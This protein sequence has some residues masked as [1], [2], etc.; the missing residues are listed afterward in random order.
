MDFP[1]ISY[2]SLEFFLRLFYIIL[3]FTFISIAGIL[4]CIFLIYGYSAYRI[5]LFLFSKI[6]HTYGL[7]RLI[8]IPYFSL[9]YSIQRRFIETLPI[10]DARNLQKTNKFLFNFT[11]ILRGIFIEEIVFDFDCENSNTVVMEKNNQTG[12]LIQM[13]KIQKYQSK[14]QKITYLKRIGIVGTENANIDYWKHFEYLQSC[15]IDTLF[16]DGILQDFEVIQKIIKKFMPDTVYCQIEIRGAH[17]PTLTNLLESFSESKIKNLICTIFPASL[18]TPEDDIISLTNFYKNH[19]N[20][21]EIICCLRQSETK[22][23]K[24]WQKGNDFGFQEIENVLYFDF[25]KWI[26]FN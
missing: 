7:Y 9:P 22:W 18:F 19:S 23:R 3:E 11:E 14:L 25:S 26:F 20:F 5:F 13:S 1:F 8:P 2:R 24:Y 12:L 16:F 17:P 15:K 6:Y 10:K 21:C 4:C